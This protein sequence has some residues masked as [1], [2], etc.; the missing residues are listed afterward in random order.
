MKMPPFKISQS[1]WQNLLAELRQRGGVQRESGAFMLAKKG[2]RE[3]AS[4]ICYDDLD[5]KALETGIITFHAVGFVKLW[6]FCQRNGL[7]VVADVHTHP[8]QWTGQ[9]ES[10]RIH[11]MVAVKGHIALILPEYGAPNCLPL[12]GA[13]V[14]EYKGN[15]KWKNHKLK[16]V[17]FQ[18]SDL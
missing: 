6:S 13:S 16:S 1:L 15:H 17:P 9:S 8:S 12:N 4:F 10:D 18:I 5:E 2:S 11:P 7:A 14:Y 3:V